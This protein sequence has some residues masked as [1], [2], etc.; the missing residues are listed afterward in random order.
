MA[1]VSH[2]ICRLD[3][4]LAGWHTFCRIDAV[5]MAMNDCRLCL[6]GCSRHVVSGTLRNGRCMMSLILLLCG[7]CWCGTVTVVCTPYKFRGLIKVVASILWSDKGLK[8]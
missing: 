3:R 4:K 7:G 6:T 2:L 8:L 5:M 1:T